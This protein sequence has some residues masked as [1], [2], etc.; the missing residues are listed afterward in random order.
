MN[1]YLPQIIEK[2]AGEGLSERM[3][4]ELRNLKLVYDMYKIM[5]DEGLDKKGHHGL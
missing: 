5:C 2:Y 1:K 3:G 4:I